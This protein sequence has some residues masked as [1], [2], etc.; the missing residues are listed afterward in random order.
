MGTV[1]GTTP[2]TRGG[3]QHFFG[4]FNICPWSADSQRMVLHRTSSTSALPRADEATEL[5]L[6]EDGRYEDAQV[7]GTTTAWNW[8]QGS[9]LQWLGPDPHHVVHN[10]RRNN[11][12]SFG[13]RVIDVRDK[14]ASDLDQPIYAIS[15]TGD[16]AYTIDF[17]RLHFARTGYGYTV[18]DTLR[19]TLDATPRDAGI[20]RMDL[21]TARSELLVPIHRLLWTSPHPSMRD[22]FHW[23]DHVQVSRD[24]ERIAF[25]HRWLTPDGLFF[26]RLMAMDRHADTVTCLVN[27]GTASH[28]DWIDGRRLVGWF[29]PERVVNRLRMTTPWFRKA[30]QPLIAVAH[31]QRKVLGRATKAV[32]GDSYFEIDVVTGTRRR[33]G[34]AELQQDGHCAISHDGRRMVIDTYPDENRLQHLSI[35]DL[36]ASQLTRVG[37]FH[38]PAEFTG[39]YRCDLHARW[40]RDGRRICFDST[41]EGHRHVY[42]HE[43]GG[44]A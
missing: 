17:V 25:L 23:V 8:Q 26:S 24:G 33:V 6:L 4:Y 10:F 1:A 20:W 43:L 40:S 39:S 41:V 31:A 2:I 30:L 32:A 34:V 19:E 28:Y 13:A 22:G 11:G 14:S 5:I 7:L 44:T 27:G 35:W 3:R 42:V 38:S 16:H 37:S 36:E 9:L 12:V 18:N 29:R 15:P 21:R